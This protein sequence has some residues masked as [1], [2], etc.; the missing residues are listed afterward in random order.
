MGLMNKVG[1]CGYFGGDSKVFDGQSVKTKSLADEL[2]TI[3]GKDSIKKV[4]TNKWKKRPFRLM[5][6]CYLMIKECENI[7]ILPAKNGVK[8]FAPLFISLNRIFNKKLHYVVIGGWLPESLSTNGKLIKYL[9]EFNGVYVESHSMVKSIEKFGL[10][11]V[12]YLPNFKRLDIINV[13]DLEYSEEEPYKLCTFS[14]VMKEKG[15]EDAI[16]AVKAVNEKNKKIVY[17]L[18]I[19]GNI[20][21]K[22]KER[23]EKLQ[24]KFPEFVEYKGVIDFKE[25]VSVI[26][27]YFVLLF[28]T[29]YEGEGFAGTILDAFAAGVPVISTNWRYNSEI[30]Q[31]EQNGILYDY[32]DKMQLSVILETI[33]HD[34]SIIN[35]MKKNC[36]LDAK[37]YSP[38]IVIKEFSR[39]LD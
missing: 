34:P 35:K 19:Y 39:H 2:G 1:I 36:I 12:I 13:N 25:S 38:D 4:N 9:S 32:K 11:N 10:K 26:K 30:I 28:P 37:L 3:Y 18:D 29:Y 17:T 20:D 23:F 15:I 16:E 14:R 27:D 8:V 5:L 24:D 7:I 22:Y 33:K 6:E 31:N 21:K